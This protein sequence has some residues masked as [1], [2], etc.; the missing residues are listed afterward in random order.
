[1]TATKAPNNTGHLFARKQPNSK[2]G[3]TRERLDADL[4]AFQEAGG[5]IEK[6]G[7]TCTLKT[8]GPMDP[9]H[10]LPV[11]TSGKSR[12]TSK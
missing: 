6:L 5:V 10:P 2:Q 7:T 9:A 3:L 8:I 1:M 4:V 12:G 11:H